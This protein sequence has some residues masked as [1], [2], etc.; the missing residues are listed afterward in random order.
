M[1]SN[2]SK[3]TC[4]ETVLQTIRN[5]G[6]ARKLPQGVVETHLLKNKENKSQEREEAKKTGARKAVNKRGT[7]MCMKC[8]II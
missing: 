3:L 2:L 4:D 5:Q 1:Q 6:N 7:K 8:D